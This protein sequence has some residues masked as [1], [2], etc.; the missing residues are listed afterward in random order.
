MTLRKTAA[1]LIAI[2]AGMLP[3]MRMADAEPVIKHVFVIA[4]ENTSAD[5]IYGNTTLAPYLNGSVLPR[6]AHA[7]NFRDRLPTLPSEPHYILMESGRHTFAD[8]SFT[9]DA[10]PSA[11]NSTAS[12]RHLVAQIMA[13][14]SVTWMTYQ[15]DISATTG[16]CPVVSRVPY[17]AKH[18]P[19]VFFQDVSGNPPSMTAPVC[20]AHTKPYSALAAD[21]AADDVANY[22][23]ITPN[24]CHDMHGNAKCPAVNRITAGDQ[25]LSSNLPP[26]LRWANRNSGVIFIIW[27]EG[28]AGS[29]KMPFF[30]LGPNVRRGLAS[31]KPFDHRS[32][33]KTVERIFNLPILSA[34]ANSTDF[35]PLFRPSTFP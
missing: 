10:D 12:R 7:T 31:G 16:D 32:L 19:F 29:N 18:N 8:T 21:L 34:V 24:L 23:Y 15:E 20:I 22:V 2:L 26:I 30:A 6:Y 3:A 9:T 35:A 17:A 25:W 27:D 4:M 5:Q 14:P 13:A 1:L 28:A 11:S 33:V